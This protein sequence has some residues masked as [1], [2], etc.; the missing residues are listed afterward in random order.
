EPRDVV[1]DESRRQPA[2]GG[3]Y[4]QCVERR[5]VAALA[6]QRALG[7]LR[8]VGE[9]PFRVGDGFGVVAERLAVGEIV[10]GA[11][12]G[13]EQPGPFTGDGIEQ[14]AG[15]AERLGALLD[16]RLR[17]GDERPALSRRG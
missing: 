4:P 8:D 1:M 5:I 7:L 11:A 2:L 17:M 13:V 12:P 10:A 15:E 6:R 16:R 14:A 9:A 3:N